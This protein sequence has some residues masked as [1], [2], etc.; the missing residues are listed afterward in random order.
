M[1]YCRPLVDLYGPRDQES[2]LIK[3]YHGVN[4]LGKTIGILTKNEIISPIRGM[5]QNPDIITQAIEETIR[6]MGTT[7]YDKYTYKGESFPN[8]VS[9]C[10][11][12]LVQTFGEDYRQLFENFSEY[13]NRRIIS[14]IYFD[15]IFRQYCVWVSQEQDIAK[16]RSKGNGYFEFEIPTE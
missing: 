5:D 13:V 4:N 11:E 1:N 6:Q 7:A 9:E 2:E 3:V 16:K 8:I 15:E 12:T 10:S 14:N